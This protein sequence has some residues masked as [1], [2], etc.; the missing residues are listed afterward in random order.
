MEIKENIK[1]NYQAAANEYNVAFY[2]VKK[3]ARVGFESWTLLRE[4]AKRYEIDDALLEEYI[5]GVFTIEE[6][7][8]KHYERYGAVQRGA[9]INA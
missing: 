4:V 2:Y 3:F 1:E 6:V 9:I 7:T 8:E 5:Y